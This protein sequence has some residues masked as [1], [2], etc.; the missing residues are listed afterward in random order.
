ML[1]HAPLMYR[2]WSFWGSMSVFQGRLHLDALFRHAKLDAGCTF[3]ILVHFQATMSC[4]MENQGLSWLVDTWAAQ[5]GERPKKY[6]VTSIPTLQLR[7]CQF[8]DSLR[9]IPTYSSWHPQRPKFLRAGHAFWGAEVSRVEVI[10]GGMLL[11]HVV[12]PE[13]LRV[14]VDAWLMF[15]MI[16]GSYIYIYNI[17]YLS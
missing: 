11:R 14:F 13:F 3:A 9:P 7:L 8:F 1:L 2:T 6:T 4:H 12:I 16:G 5:D 10:V 17:P 15:G